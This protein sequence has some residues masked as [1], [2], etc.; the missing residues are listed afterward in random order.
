[1]FIIYIN[2]VPSLPLFSSSLLYSDDTKCFK[3]TLSSADYSLIQAHLTQLLLWTKQNFPSFNVSKCCLLRFTNNCTS[4][5]TCPYE[6]DNTPI[7]C[8]NSCKDLGV[9]FSALVLS[10]Q[11]TFQGCNI[12]R[13]SP[14]VFI[15]M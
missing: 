9:K 6:I 2:E 10:F 12:T 4:P 14:L 7:V 3:H 1:M 8:Q 15:A 5:V 13:R 11:V